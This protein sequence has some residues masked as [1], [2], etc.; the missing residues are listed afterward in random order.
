MHLLIA[1]NAFKN[2]LAAGAAARAVQEGLK[3]SRLVCT[4][5]CFPI[6]DG[7][8]GT[9]DLIIERLEGSRSVAEARD[10]LGRRI[11]TYLGLV[12]DGN[13]AVIEMANASGLRLLENKELD[14]LHASSCG[15]GDL[16][17]SALDKEVSRVIIG[18]GGSAT[19][20][21]GTGIL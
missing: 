18:M 7:G 4:S 15:T 17:R 11:K 2:S 16:I 20:D 12:E 9:G 13:T 8:D 10:P 19:V 14:A 5:E 6:G 1:P 21:G 3:A